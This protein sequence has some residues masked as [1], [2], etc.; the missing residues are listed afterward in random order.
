MTQAITAKKNTKINIYRGLRK[1]EMQRTL[2]HCLL[3]SNWSK[4]ESLLF[5]SG[6]F[7]SL[8]ATASSNIPAVDRLAAKKKTITTQVSVSQK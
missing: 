1:D 6:L 7:S 8:V 5:T 2:H 3:V 4:S